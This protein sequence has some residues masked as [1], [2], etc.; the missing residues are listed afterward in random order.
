MRQAA[1]M[2]D[3]DIAKVCAEVRP[4]ATRVGGAGGAVGGG[5]G[6]TVSTKIQVVQFSSLLYKSIE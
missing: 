5:T 3:A 2:V 4:E 6:S 1:T